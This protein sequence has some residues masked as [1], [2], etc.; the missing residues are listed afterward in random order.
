MAVESA[1]LGDDGK[2][3]TLKFLEAAYQKRSPGIVFLQ[4]EPVFD[5][6]HPDPR[7]RVLIKK[8]GLPPA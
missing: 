8:I 5:F 2:E 7:Y 3:E 4:N 1:L 6:L